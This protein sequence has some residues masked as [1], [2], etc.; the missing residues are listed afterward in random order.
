M[1]KKLILSAAAG[2]LALVLGTVAAEAQTISFL[3]ATTPASKWGDF[4]DNNSSCPGGTTPSNYLWTFV[5]DGVTRTGSFVTHQFTS[6]FCAYTVK[7]TI[8]CPTGT[9]TGTRFACFG[10]GTP[11]CI[12]PGPFN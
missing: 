10:C 1:K 8:T 2:L 9:Y 3:G 11:G 5:E 12:N 6:S 4:V 7:L